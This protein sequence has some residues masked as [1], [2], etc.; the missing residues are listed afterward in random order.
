MVVEATERVVDVDLVMDSMDVFYYFM[1]SIIFGV[2]LGR[3]HCKAICS[4]VEVGA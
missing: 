4:G 3:S 2:G 1:V